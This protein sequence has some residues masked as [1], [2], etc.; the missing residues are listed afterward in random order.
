MAIWYVKKVDKNALTKLFRPISITNV[1][2]KMIAQIPNERYVKRLAKKIYDRQNQYLV[3]TRNL[4]KESFEKVFNVLDGRWLFKYMIPEILQFILEQGKADALK[5]EITFMINDN[6]QRNLKLLV[7][8]AQKIKML[9]VVTEDVCKFEGLEKYL[10]NEKGIAIRVTNNKRKALLKSSIIFNIDFT[11]EMFNKFYLPRK[12]A[13]ININGK[14]FIKSKKFEGINCNYYKI[15]LPSQFE[16]W[17][18]ISELL[19]YTDECILLESMI[20]YRNSYEDIRNGIKGAT[21]KGL[22]GNNG[23]IKQEEILKVFT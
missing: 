21:I 17:F 14:M 6:N 1:E 16:E 7:E 12:S 5:Q 11:Q 3:I 22:V 13:I 20:Y 23:I 15:S 10:L 2:N 4:N 18:R 19:D 9:N 8:I